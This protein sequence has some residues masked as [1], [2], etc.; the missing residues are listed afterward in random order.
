ML[1]AEGSDFICRSDGRQKSSRHIG[2]IVL[3]GQA[4]PFSQS[5]RKRCC[6]MAGF[7]NSSLSVII[8]CTFSSQL[9]KVGAGGGCFVFCFQNAVFFEMLLKSYTLCSNEITVFYLIGGEFFICYSN[10]EK[11]LNSTSV[12]QYCIKTI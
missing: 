6:V 3:F 5:K 8:E 7:E 12:A 2:C 11:R 1:P 4:C 10:F 9:P